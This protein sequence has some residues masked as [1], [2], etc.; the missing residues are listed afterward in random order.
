L[1][2]FAHFRVVIHEEYPLHVAITSFCSGF[3]PAEPGMLP[4]D[5]AEHD[6]FQSGGIPPAR[7]SD[8]AAPDVPCWRRELP[9]A[10]SRIIRNM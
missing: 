5:A 9:D 10:T 1:Q 6:S 8:G 4:L 2:T 7:S 3:R